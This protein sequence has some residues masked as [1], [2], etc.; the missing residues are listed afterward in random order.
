[1]LTFDPRDA[2]TMVKDGVAV[3]GIGGVSGPPPEGE[4]WSERPLEDDWTANVYQV[5]PQSAITDVIGH[6][7]VVK[8]GDVALFDV[9]SRSCLHTMS[10]VC[11]VCQSFRF[12]TR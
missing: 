11:R 10:P 9:S 7:L 3:G 5:Q 6:K 4:D 2:F 1:M 12:C 8:A